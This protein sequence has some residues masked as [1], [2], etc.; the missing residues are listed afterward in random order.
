MVTTSPMPTLQLGSQGASVKELQTLLNQR[1]A[2]TL[3]VDGIFGANTHSAVREFQLLFFLT[4]DGIVGPKTWRALQT[5]APVDMPKIARNSTG[6]AVKQAQEALKALKY[7]SGNVD[8]I[9]G[10]QT[11]TAVQAFQAHHFLNPDGIVST[12]TWT[13][14]NQVWV[15]FVIV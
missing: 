3:I 13:K 7:Y 2:A 12:Q 4:V 6:T 15:G 10:P 9:F 11:E 8:G 14:L 1:T 5:G